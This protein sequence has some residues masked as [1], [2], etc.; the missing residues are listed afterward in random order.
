MSWRNIFITN[1]CKLSLKDNQLKIRQEIDYFVPLEDIAAIII[2]A[3]EVVLTAPLFSACAKYGVSIIFSDDNFSPCGQFLSFN[4]HHRSLKI[5]Q[6]QINISSQL[7]AILWQKIITRKILNQAFVLSTIGEENYAAYL[8]EICGKIKPNDVE[9]IEARAAA[10]YFPVLFGKG[11][12][13]SRDNAVNI[14][15]NYAYSIIRSAVSRNICA[16]GF[17]P[18]LGIWHKNELNPFNLSDDLIECFRQTAD[19]FIYQ[20]YIEDGLQKDF[21]SSEKAKIIKILNYEIISDGAKHSLLSAID[22]TVKSLS[23]VLKNNDESYLILPETVLPKE[24]EYE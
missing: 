16:Y 19:L 10:L 20:K 15:L 11:F 5:I 14:R 21:N 6:S 12:A 13:R 1:P 18:A 23:T 3:R 4:Q 7:K 9:N 8:T 22:K 24:T 17:L 2:E